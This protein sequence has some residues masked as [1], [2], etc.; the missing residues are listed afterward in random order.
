MSTYAD[1]SKARLWLDGDA[2]R[3]PAETALPADIYAAT[4]VGW[5]AFGGIQAGFEVERTQQRTPLSI[6]NKGGIYRQSKGDEDPTVRM[7]PVDMSKATAL[8]LLTGGSIAAA[9][10][11]FEWIEGESEFFALI[12]RLVDGND[13]MAYYCRKAELSN[14][15]TETLNDEQLMGWDMEITP[16]VPADGSK[17]IRRITSNNPLA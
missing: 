3:A 15:P 2:F 7:R 11:G 5:D 4:L 13:K 12:L 14:R 16:L 10:S 1:S 17:P 8:T 9:A 6:W